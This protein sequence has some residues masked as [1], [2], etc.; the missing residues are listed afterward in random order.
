MYEKVGDHLKAF[1]N[2]RFLKPV[3]GLTDLKNQKND[4][5]KKPAKGIVKG[6]IAKGKAKPG[7]GIVKARGLS[8][9]RESGWQLYCQGQGE[10]GQGLM[11]HVSCMTLMQLSL[12]FFLWVTFRK[13]S[14]FYFLGVMHR[15]PQH[16]RVCV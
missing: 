4:N 8:R 1:C 15:L 3:Y 11:G 12:V 7:K 9:A 2:P 16:V 13:T 6:K 14:T 5:D 10:G